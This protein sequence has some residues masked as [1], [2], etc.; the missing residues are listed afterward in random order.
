MTCTR[1]RIDPTCMPAAASR[2]PLRVLAWLLCLGFAFAV[3][4]ARPEAAHAQASNGSTLEADTGAGASA[5]QPSTAAADDD[6]DEYDD[7]Y[8][9]EYEIETG[10]GVPDPYADLEEITITGK[11]TEGTAQSI[12]E[13]ITSFNEEQMDVMGITN[14]ESLSLNTPSLHV[15]RFGSQAVVTLRGV[16]VENLT[17]VG[18]TGV[19]F[20]YDGIHQGRALNGPVNFYDVQGVQVTRG[21][22]GGKGGRQ[23]TGGRITIKSKPPEVEPNVFGDVQLGNYNAYLMRGV[24]NYPIFDEALMARVTGGYEKRDG[25]Q[26]NKFTN[27]TKD[28]LDD[29]NN[30]AV[31]GQLRSLL[32]DESLELRGIGGYMF[33]KGN[34]VGR[35][36][37]FGLPPETGRLTRGT[38]APA[39]L[40][41]LT[42][43][44]YRYDCDGYFS[45]GGFGSFAPP[46]TACVATDP[47]KTYSDNDDEISNDQSYFT[48]IMNWD[49]PYFQ[50][51][52]W[53]SDIRLGAVGGYIN[54]KTTGNLD[55]DLTNDPSGIFDQDR[56]VN[57]GS[58]EAFIE[59]PDVERFDFKVGGYYFQEE[60]KTQFCLDTKGDSPGNDVYADQR[61]KT[62]SIA[63]YAHAGYRLFD[64][65]RLHGSARY[66][67]EQK[68]A[69]QQTLAFTYNEFDRTT[70][71]WTQNLP[72]PTDCGREFVNIR[73]STGLLSPSTKVYVEA[74]VSRDD[75]VKSATWSKP[76]FNGGFDWTVT[77][78]STIGV[79]YTNSFKS[80]GFPLGNDVRNSDFV[81]PIYNAEEVAEYELSFKN[82]FFE[83]RLQANLTLFWMDYDPF[84]IC[85]IEGA[86]YKCTTTGKATTRGIELEVT[87]SPV[88]G[89]FINGHFN[90]LDAK[91]DQFWLKDPT[92][93]GLNGLLS[94]LASA[95]NVAG[96]TLPKAPTFAGS[97][98]IQYNLDAGR[99]G[100]FSPRIQT[101]A[102]SRTYFRVFNKEI[103]SQKPFAKVDVSLDW[104]SEDERLSV[105]LYV[106]NVTDVDVLNFLFI[107]PR[108]SSGAVTGGSYLPPRTFGFRFG[109]NYTSDLF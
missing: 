34:G 93:S 47:R 18:E 64:N 82:Q 4:L 50:D 43:I 14:A 45:S 49:M 24:V 61:V 58:V 74:R 106:N 40:R 87:S 28:A 103:F 42:A 84:Q 107:A 89:L 101:Q 27:R 63:G 21:P 7:E 38:D 91:V 67:V 98:G 54:T 51:N 30:M 83:N 104:L 100:I 13:A 78:T 79:D 29:A 59:R 37:L 57:Q 95:T 22:T 97:L 5:A 1:P 31:R 62:R 73:K 53:L 92:D 44:Y 94:S 9:D 65:L 108:I 96:N 71:P 68:D 6:E 105:R 10:D 3:S 15:G 80:G 75:A 36:R 41:D 35:T 55:L 99:A 20:E 25:Y 11:A 16:G 8:A 23:T 88:D 2:T 86:L 90:Y 77:D 52:A 81:E 32:F 48:G 12:P 69:D 26:E 109:V 19:G 72:N 60:V 17:A 70:T 102:Q 66:T 56:T 39:S 33:Q 76:T 85:Q 46:G